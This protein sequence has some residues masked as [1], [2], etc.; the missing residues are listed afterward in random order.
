VKDELEEAVFLPLQHPHLFQGPIRTPART[1]LLHGPPGTGKTLLVEKVA[2]EAGFMLLSVSPS[3]VLSKWAGD[4]EKAVRGVFEVAK[5]FQPCII[6]LVRPV[7]AGH[8]VCV[9]C[10]CKHLLC[11][12]QCA[13]ACRRGM[14]AQDEVDSLGQAR[15]SNTDAGARRLLTELLIQFTHA[16]AEEGVYVFGATNR[17]QVR[18]RASILNSVR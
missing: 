7:L 11:A 12:P 13:G 9:R 10:C 15:G 4:S 18:A 16:A 8:G 1:F 3:M 14:R 6:F 2:A 17:M 5:S